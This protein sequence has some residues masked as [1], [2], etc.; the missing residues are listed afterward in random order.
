[1]GCC[2]SSE[3]TD[4][5]SRAPDPVSGGNGVQMTPGNSAP[6]APREVSPD[7]QRQRAGGP[8]SSGYA[9][10]PSPAPAPASGSAVV[11][12]VP[13]PAQVT[14][15]STSSTDVSV[16]IAPDPIIAAGFADI[17]FFEHF[18]RKTLGQLV[19]LFYSST[20][21]KDAV[22]IAEGQRDDSFHLIVSGS[23]RVSAS[24]R[25]ATTPPVELYDLGPNKW[26]GDTGLVSDNMQPVAVTALEATT[27]LS[28]A[29][30]QYATFVKSCPS[31][32][33][34]N[35]QVRQYQFFASVLLNLCV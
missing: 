7:R 23:V 2:A 19:K 1:M 29:R 3:T 8:G 33:T 14:G 10:V 18:D 27:V 30:K 34:L 35:V 25:D 13:A 28:L 24:S 15:A 26:F 6:R 22:I 21:D 4:P 9:P 31:S 12:P 17:P 20:F 5:V 32:A 11:V 16:S